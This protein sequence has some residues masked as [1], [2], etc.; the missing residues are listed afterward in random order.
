[1]EDEDDTVKSVDAFLS[2]VE[3][4]TSEGE[5][6]VSEQCDTVLT[7]KDVIE[8]RLLEQNVSEGENVEDLKLEDTKMQELDEYG[9]KLVWRRKRRKW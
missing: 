8:S 1:M 6:Q 9:L 3:E 5:P 2:T 7:A 4:P